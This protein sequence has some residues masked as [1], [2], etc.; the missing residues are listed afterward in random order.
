M[1]DKSLVLV[2]ELGK[3]TEPNAGKHPRKYVQ[4]LIVKEVIYYACNPVYNSC[5]LLS[6]VHV[7]DDSIAGTLPVSYVAQ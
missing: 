2:D 7:V 4:K 5:C 1:S 3:G 6:T